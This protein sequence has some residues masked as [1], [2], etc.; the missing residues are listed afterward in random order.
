MSSK[1]NRAGWSNIPTGLV[2]AS[3]LTKKVENG[4]SRLEIRDANVVEK[5]NMDLE[6][7]IVVSC[8][9]RNESGISPTLATLFS[10]LKELFLQLHLDPA[11]SNTLPAS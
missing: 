5:Q 10:I 2:S 6:N 3:S 7:L 1:Q 11:S 4:L 9:N 8:K